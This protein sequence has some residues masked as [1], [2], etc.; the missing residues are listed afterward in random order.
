MCKKAFKLAPRTVL[1]SKNFCSGAYRRQA[2]RMG[3]GA[4]RPIARG[5]KER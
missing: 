5:V 3:R 4:D 1:G 2:E